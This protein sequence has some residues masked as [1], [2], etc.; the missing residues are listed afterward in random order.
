V[1][2][3]ENNLVALFVLF[4]YNDLTLTNQGNIM[5]WL[6]REEN[7]TKILDEILHH[8]ADVAKDMMLDDG[9]EYS[10]INEIEQVLKRNALCPDMLQEEIEMMFAELREKLLDKLA[11]TRLEVRS[12]TLEKDGLKDVDYNIIQLY[13]WSDDS[14]ERS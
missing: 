8:Q 2:G 6:L 5:S 13:N 10:D 1:D 11:S 4:W 9:E 3:Q 7:I 12:I 14:S